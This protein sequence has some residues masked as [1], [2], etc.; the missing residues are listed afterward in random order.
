MT[1][2]VVD[3]VEYGE[4]I[5]VPAASFYSDHRNNVIK[6]LFDCIEQEVGDYA[7]CIVNFLSAEVIVK[8][9]SPEDYMM[10]VLKD[11]RQDRLSIL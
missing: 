5:Y 2:I 11:A 4:R 10:Y 7:E 6:A 8:F 9:Y 3:L 1:E